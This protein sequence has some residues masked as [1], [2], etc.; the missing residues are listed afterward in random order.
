[1]H[2][3]FSIRAFYLSFFY[4]IWLNRNSFDKLKSL[5]QFNS[6]LKKVSY[7]EQEKEKIILI[8]KTISQVEKYAPWKP[9]CYNLALVSKYLLEKHKIPSSINIGFRKRN[10]KME[11]HAWVNCKNFIVS[12][13]VNNLSSYSLLKQIKR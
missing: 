8:S 6:D 4:Q 3:L 12:G 13:Y 2:I 7:N 10:N 11:G 1:M 9:K 5:H